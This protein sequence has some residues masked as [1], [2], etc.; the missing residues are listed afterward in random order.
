MVKAYSMTKVVSHLVDVGMIKKTSLPGCL[1]KMKLDPL[2]EQVELFCDLFD[3]G[4]VRK[5]DFASD[6]FSEGRRT[7]VRTFRTS[8]KFDEQRQNRSFHRG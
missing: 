2:F 8:D 5:F 1:K 4:G 6:E 3:D 7:V